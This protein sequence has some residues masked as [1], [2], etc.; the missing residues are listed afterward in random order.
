MN[1]LKKKF[2]EENFQTENELIVVDRKMESVAGH[3]EVE[4]YMQIDLINCRHLQED[5][6]ECI[7]HQP[8]KGI[9]LHDRACCNPCMGCG[10]REVSR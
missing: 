8:Y 3:I 10:F 6:C 5:H 2:F 9:I 1:D 4:D 7:C